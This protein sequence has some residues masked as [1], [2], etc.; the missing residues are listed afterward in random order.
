MLGVAER[1]GRGVWGEI[2]GDER[3][4]Q[5]FAIFPG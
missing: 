1:G 3:E 4:M 5:M 2:G